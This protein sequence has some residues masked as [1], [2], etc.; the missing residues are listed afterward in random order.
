[1][2]ETSLCR[3]IVEAMSDNRRYRHLNPEV[4][5]DEDDR[6]VLRTTLLVLQSDRPLV[7]CPRYKPNDGFRKSKTRST[8]ETT[9]RRS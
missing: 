3:V 6:A 4:I 2:G 9:I 8:P 7:G 1:M 5:V